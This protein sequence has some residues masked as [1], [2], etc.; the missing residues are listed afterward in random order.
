MCNSLRNLEQVA[1]LNL[2]LAKTI[3]HDILNHI[4]N[5]GVVHVFINKPGRT[6]RIPTS[7]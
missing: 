5:N 4:F 7:T 2:I 1:F 6:E 3:R